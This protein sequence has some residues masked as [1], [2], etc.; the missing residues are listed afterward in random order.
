M[1]REGLGEALAVSADVTLGVT[2][3]AMGLPERWHTT[4]VGFAFLAVTWALVWRRDDAQVRAAG[5]SLGGLVIPGTLAPASLARE[6]AV[7]LVWAA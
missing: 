1:R 5:L 3:I 4:L 6:I 7:A 2:A